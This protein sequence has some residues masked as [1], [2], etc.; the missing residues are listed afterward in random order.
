MVVVER[1]DVDSEWIFPREALR[2]VLRGRTEGKVGSD[3][4]LEVFQWFRTLVEMSLCPGYHIRFL[5][6]VVEPT[7]LARF[8]HF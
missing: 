4:L 6:C 7:V 8:V 1:G 5:Q 3:A 2:Q